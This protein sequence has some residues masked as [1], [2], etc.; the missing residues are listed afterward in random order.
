MNFHSSF[1]DSALRSPRFSHEEKDGFVFDWE[2]ERKGKARRRRDGGSSRSKSSGSG[3]CTKTRG[4]FDGPLGLLVLNDSINGLE[5]VSEIPSASTSKDKEQRKPSRRGSRTCAARQDFRRTNSSPALLPPFIYT[6]ECD[7]CGKSETRLKTK[8]VPSK[9]EKSIRS[10]V[11]ECSSR[12]RRSRRSVSDLA[13]G[14]SRS[15]R[16]RRSLI[17]EKRAQV[18]L[19]RA[20]T[21]GSN[22]ESSRSL[23]PRRSKS[24]RALL[25][26]KGAPPQRQASAPS[27]TSH[28][29][30]S[31]KDGRRSSG[32]SR[33]PS[34]SARQRRTS[35]S[36]HRR[37]SS[38]SGSNK[39]EAAVTSDVDT[40]AS[41]SASASAAASAASRAAALAASL[42]PLASKGQQLN[43]TEL[44]KMLDLLA[45]VSSAAAKATEAT[46]EMIAASSD[47]NTVITM[48]SSSST[49]T[50]GSGE[51]SFC[52]H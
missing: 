29:C 40:L 1:N 2:E 52:L 15:L 22:N 32:K 20:S 26:T 50:S 4:S 5:E 21:T 3:E 46:E 33:S 25:L 13:E 7:S 42:I 6:G 43:P 39:E 19:R 18:L 27:L 24:E 9:D 34:H 10:E 51:D 11:T 49:M 30:H 37:N 35:K 31:S 16:C 28:R 48:N 17:S 41:A 44:S 8:T 12:S 47:C 23:R 14:S 38:T 45:Q 36:V